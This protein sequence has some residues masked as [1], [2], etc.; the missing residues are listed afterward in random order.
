VGGKFFMD[1]RELPCEFR[2]QA[3]EERLWSACK[4]LVAA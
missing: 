1:H 2:S 3:V 4:R